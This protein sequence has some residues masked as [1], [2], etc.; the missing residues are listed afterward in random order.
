MFLIKLDYDSN[1]RTKCRFAST[2]KILQPKPLF[3]GK[4]IL[5]SEILTYHKEFKTPDHFSTLQIVNILKGFLRATQATTSFL[6]RR[7]NDDVVC[8]QTLR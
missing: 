7:Q 5:F 6:K 3:E 2:K 1:L 8:Q 4:K